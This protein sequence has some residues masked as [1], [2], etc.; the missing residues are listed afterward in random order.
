[1]LLLSGYVLFP[2]RYNDTDGFWTALFKPDSLMIQ[3][4][5]T[6]THVKGLLAEIFSRPTYLYLYFLVI[7]FTFA[8]VMTPRQGKLLTRMCSVVWRLAL[9]VVAIVYMGMVFLPLES[10]TAPPQ[11]PFKAQ[12]Q[13]LHKLL[14]PF[15]ASNSYGLFRRMTGVGQ[16]PPSAKT[17]AHSWGRLQPSV[18]E[19][20]V[21]VVEG[22]RDGRTWLEIP[23]RYAPYKPDRAPRRT[24]PHQPRLDWQMWFAALGSY[25]HNPWFVHLMLKI[26]N[27]APDAIALL[28]TNEYPFM[29]APPK[30]VKATLYHYDFTRVPSPWADRNPG[31]T[32]YSPFI[33]NA[34]RGSKEH[35]L[36]WTR[37][38]AGEYIPAV[39]KEAL[40]DIAGRNGWPT[41]PLKKPS[42]LCRAPTVSEFSLS[43]VGSQL[44]Y[45]LCKATMH[46]RSSGEI[47]RKFVGFK[48]NCPLFKLIWSGASTQCFI[49]GPL[50]IILAVIFIPVTIA[51]LCRRMVDRLWV[52]RNAVERSAV[53]HALDTTSHRPY[54]GAEAELT[55]KQKRA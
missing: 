3:N 40:L 4:L 22:S 32:L 38:P 16:V 49:D 52:G 54:F 24:A 5:L 27:G 30:V 37:K 13:Q 26:L 2:I 20:P 29:S 21:V 47:L 41:A 7:L 17:A 48:F 6:A 44:R 53:E 46:A 42:A 25:Q 8:H 55:E 34:T 43:W 18:V 15:H 9:G 50:L 39:N 23:F 14:Q 12:S 35:N 33:I 28:D 1:M 19:V 31:T 51:E 45:T 11:I 10:I 36:W